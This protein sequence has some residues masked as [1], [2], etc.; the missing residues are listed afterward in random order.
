M[1]NR[2]RVNWECKYKDSVNENI[3]REIFLFCFFKAGEEKTKLNGER[4]LIILE[5]IFV[6]FK[7]SFDLG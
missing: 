2:F 6:K 4:V 5:G 7:S 3:R 1:R